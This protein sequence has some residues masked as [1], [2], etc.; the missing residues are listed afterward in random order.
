MEMENWATLQDIF[1]AALDL[2]VVERE[3]FIKQRCH[4]NASLM[5]QVH[6]LLTA[7]QDSESFL[8]DLSGQLYPLIKE[9]FPQRESVAHYQLQEQIGEGGM[10][11]VYRA[12]DTQLK[13]T[14]AIKFMAISHAG[15][16][17]SRERF[18]HEAKAAAQLQ[19][20][21]LC[22]VF[23]VGETEEGQL[24]IVT[25]FCE[26]Q[27][28]SALISAK[29]LSIGNI[30]LIFIQLSDAL[31][32]A[33]SKG[34][35]HRDL[36][37]ANIIVEPSMALKL[38][39][40]GV[41]KI[42]GVDI[43]LSGEIVGSVAYIAPEQFSNGSVDQRSDIWSLGVLFYETLCGN[44]P[45]QGDSASSVMYQL[46]HSDV[47]QLSMDDVPVLAQFNQIISRCLQLDAQYR[48]SD[49]A[50]L[51]ADLKTLQRQL[52]EQQLLDIIPRREQKTDPV[53]HTHSTVFEELRKVTAVG[54]VYSGNNVTLLKN[55][56]A[57]IVRYG[58]HIVDKPQRGTFY[59]YF[60]YPN[61]GEG[62]AD[63][64]LA[65]ATNTLQQC[66]SQAE[67]DRLNIVL[68]TIS[69]LIS[70][71][72]EQAAPRITGDL[73]GALQNLLTVDSNQAVILTESVFRRLRQRFPLCLIQHISSSAG[74]VLY[75]LDSPLQVQTTQ[76]YATPFIGR[77]HELG[78]LKDNWQ[79]MLEGESKAI[80]VS[81]E[82]GIGKTRLIHE[83]KLNCLHTDNTAL[84]EFVCDP[85]QSDSPFYPVIQGIKQGL[86]HLFEDHETVPQQ[87]EMSLKCLLERW[88]KSL[89]LD[90][91][92]YLPYLSW[93]LR[94]DESDHYPQWQQHSPES[95]KRQG[96][97]SLETCI[98]AQAQKQP[99]LWIIEDLHWVDSSTLEWLERLLGKALPEGVMLVFSGRLEMFQRWRT[100]S[101]VTHLAL[102]KLSKL[103]T[104]KLIR[105]II[106]TE[107][108]EQN[109]EAKIVEKTAGNP[110]FI[111][112][113]TQMLLVERENKENAA[114]LLQVPDSLQET[115]LSRLDKLG[116]AKK[117][118]QTAAVIG[119]VFN[120]EMLFVL[121]DCTPVT[122]DNQLAQLIEANIIFHQNQEA[123]QYIFKHAL[124]QDALYLALPE[125]QRQSLHLQLAEQLQSLLESKAEGDGLD[126]KAELVA[127]HFSAAKQPV[128]ATPLWLQAARQALQTHATE[129]SIALSQNGLQELQHLP[130]GTQRDEWEIA[131]QMTLG[132]ALMATKGYSDLGV[133]NAYQRALD[134]CDNSQNQQLVLPVLFGLWTYLI[135]RAK[136]KQG[137][138]LTQR[139]VQIAESEDSDDFRVEAYL[140]HGMNNYYL[141]F[142][143]K[144]K[145]SLD[146]CLSYYKPEMT[147]THALVYGQ[148]PSVIAL[149]Y[150]SW[151]I[152]EEGEND[153]ARQLSDQA[154]SRARSCKHP[155]TLCYA[156]VYAA[157][158]HI[159]SGDLIH[160]EQLVQD[161]LKLC[162]MQGVKEL[163]KLTS[164]FDGILTI[165]K[166][167]LEKGLEQFRTAM[168]IFK[169]TGAEM[170]FPLW[171][172]FEA[173]TLAQ[174]GRMEE[175]RKVLE[176]AKK[177]A[178][179]DSAWVY[180]PRIE[181]GLKS[182][183]AS[184]T[185]DNTR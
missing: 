53:F 114:S 42:A 153:Q 107:Q 170:F 24:Y 169:T 103:D 87:N 41:A 159:L 175:A 82:A 3:Q 38:I 129:E 67:Q 44:R 128:Q 11:V 20:R 110:L 50:L 116:S 162:E 167:E 184:T 121:L 158:V 77:Y 6:A 109:L 145:A 29:Q 16:D 33:H 115:L 59:A 65:C 152:Q 32:A 155:F 81:G 160:A 34:I 62:A 45:F 118:V 64:A 8:T 154:M 4:N 161:N 182:L 36:K 177:Q 70:V 63:S 117:T 80:L 130:S 124:I 93:I 55:I 149:S 94:L 40:F 113:Y 17:R 106:P 165:G 156:Q 123:H 151:I 27:N 132:P 35:F 14:V 92:Q 148:D 136:F 125:V 98:A 60:G 180:L 28:L 147:E 1:N 127:H 119:R 139:M 83:L 2:P 141:G 181:Q 102:A 46:F 7:C 120:A 157:A 79:Q 48:Y 90:G 173:Q 43:S 174:L 5:A 105:S 86:L 111:E 89:Q 49:A 21:N 57:N 61:L 135:V 122:L 9:Q 26:G 99:L 168:A 96:L 179:A 31:H 166:G 85:N 39:D 71:E 134:L 78:L 137:I 140:G 76:R 18:M 56:V 54:V 138:R 126:I 10:G 74:L 172:T 163:F 178:E 66:I 88:M 183:G 47:P 144:A 84:L 51:L 52:Q 58:G 150:L 97:S 12:F 68:D 25:P 37:P 91:A 100:H 112:E 176:Q 19:H 171:M 164:V 133:A 185:Q 30:L 73:P 101:D 23:E 131:L 108:I 72:N 15:S 69:L 75:Q 13:R 104:Q 146:K 142:R 143:E 22:D 95:L